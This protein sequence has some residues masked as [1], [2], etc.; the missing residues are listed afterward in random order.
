M[1]KI[2]D[3][4]TP[5]IKI[6]TPRLIIDDITEKDK[7]AY[8]DLYT[9]E[10]LN[11]WWG[12]DYR[13]DLGEN[14]PTPEY[15]YCFMQSLKEKKEEYSFAIRHDGKMIGELVLYNFNEDQSAEMGFR[16]SKD[17]QGQGFAYEGANALKDYAFNQL[18]VKALKTKCFKQNIPSKRLIEKLG[19]SKFEE[20][21]THFYFLLKNSTT[22][23]E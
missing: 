21:D 10:Q 3:K 5:P 12:Y 4:I 18:K 23:T 17:Y 15:F 19:F 8:F 7:Q 9:D 13:E 16:L 14:A 22:F 11:R 20:S 2:F 6:K 1:E